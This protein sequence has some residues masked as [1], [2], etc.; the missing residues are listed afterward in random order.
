[1]HSLEL[2]N[3]NS[4]TAGLLAILLIALSSSGC[5]VDGVQTQT[6]MVTESNGT[7]LVTPERADRLQ[8]EDGL[9][10]HCN[11]GFGRLADRECRCVR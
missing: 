9:L 8:C 4:T 10:L 1:M 7:F 2:I 6:M 3:R 11:T 5:V